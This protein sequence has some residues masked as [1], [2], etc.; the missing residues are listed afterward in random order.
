MSLS[1]LLYYRQLQKVE[2]KHM[3]F[4]SSWA[5]HSFSWLVMPPTT[6]LNTSCFSSYMTFSFI[7][8]IRILLMCVI[9]IN[10]TINFLEYLSCFTIYDLL[11]HSDNPHIINVCHLNKCHYQHCFTIDSYKR[12]RLNTWDCG[13]LE[14]H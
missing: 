6:Y 13:L 5:T 3:R 11:F 9:W 2:V 12:S 8:I 7:V 1:T 10:V 4:W 14:Q